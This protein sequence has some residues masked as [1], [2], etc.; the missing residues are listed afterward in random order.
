MTPKVVHVVGGGTV[1]HV[2][3]HLALC[4]P[5][6]GGTARRLV[7]LCK[8]HDQTMDVILHLT[9]MAD[10]KSRIERQRT[11]PCSLPCS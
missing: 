1:S 5:A 4:A 10:P 11:L 7:E 2:R 9:K 3:A 6:Y 8:E